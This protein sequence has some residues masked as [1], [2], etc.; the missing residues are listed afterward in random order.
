MKGKKYLIVWG[1]IILGIIGYIAYDRYDYTRVVAPNKLSMK[2][3][4]EDFNQLY[5]TIVEGYPFLEVNKRMNGVDFVAK[6]EEY[7]KRISSTNRDSKFESVLHSVIKDLNNDHSG[8]VSNQFMKDLQAAYLYNE[9]YKSIYKDLFYNEKVIN[10]YGNTPSKEELSFNE[11]NEQSNLVTKDVIKNKVAYMHLPKMLRASAVFNK[12]MKQIEKYISTRRNY[13]SLI[14]D[15]RGNG[16][17]YTGYWWEI[18]SKL[19]KEPVKNRIYNLFRTNNPVINEYVY[20]RPGSEENLRKIKDLPISSMPNAPKEAMG[21]FTHFAIEEQ[22]NNPDGKSGFNG[23]IYLLVD[24]VVYSAAEGLAS[25]CKETGFATLVGEATGGDGIGS[26]PVLF[27]LENSGI[28]VRMSSMM[29]LTES[30]VCNEEFKT[31]PDVMVKD[32]TKAEDFT[33]DKCIQK[34]IELQGIK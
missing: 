34:V 11:D 20:G 8:I 32:C 15:I 16:G 22:I 25:F 23:K 31:T 26:D 18:I 29:G 5:T 9:P 30:G 14:I 19:T 21:M 17:G 1:L 27:N 3:K 28:V 6:K 33:D 10:R 13:E 24:S 4:V 2:D 12:D 7:L